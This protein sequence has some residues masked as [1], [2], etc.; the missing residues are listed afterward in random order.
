MIVWD[1]KK[2]YEM[3]LCENNILFISN[4]NMT[5]QQYLEAI[6]IKYKISDYTMQTVKA[7]AEEIA[8]Y[9]R[10]LWWIYIKGIYYSW[11]M[12]RWTAVSINFDT[13]ICI[14]FEN[15]AFQDL[16]TMYKR[17]YDKL[18]N[19]YINVK[20]QR[21]S[22]WIPQK[23]I[24]VVPSRLIKDSNNVNLRDSKAQTWKQTNIHIHAEYI[25]KYWDINIIKL[26]KVWKNL[27][28]VDIKSFWLEILS[29]NALKDYSWTELLWPKLRYVRNYIKDND[30]YSMRLIDPANANNDIMD[31]IEYAEK[32]KLKQ[33]AKSSLN[34]KFWKNIIR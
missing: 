33:L 34:E 26:L 32:W 30:L 22:V 21:V 27:H 9:I 31:S 12:S 29:I 16:S 6:L 1:I 17:T 14:E 28:N 20:Q 3:L 5:E 7:S 8:W 24:D 18:R 19:K 23:N 10:T 4:E 25:K 2:I 11:S 13:D 15:N